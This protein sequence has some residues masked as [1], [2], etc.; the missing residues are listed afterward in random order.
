M[1]GGGEQ[2]RR[3]AG[4]QENFSLVRSHSVCVRARVCWSGDH[5]GKKKNAL[6]NCSELN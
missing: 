3:R 2:E 6:A 1:K 5:A 4:K